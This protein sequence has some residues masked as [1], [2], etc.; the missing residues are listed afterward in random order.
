MKNGQ[1]KDILDRTF[2]FGIRVIK[3]GN[4]LPR[5]PAGYALASQLIR[6]G[7]SIGANIQE[8][9]SAISKKDFIHCVQISLKEARETKFWIELITESSITP[10]AKTKLLIDE[11]NQLISILTI[12]AK[13]AKINS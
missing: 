4:S 10:S 3:M 1:R 5:T 8:A 2:K 9:Q 6:S 12:I 11:S 13:H 7:T